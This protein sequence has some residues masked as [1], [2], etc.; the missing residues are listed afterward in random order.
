M[1]ADIK[2]YEIKISWSAED[3]CFFARVPAIEGCMSHGNTLEEAAG[4]IREAF[5]GIIEAMDAHGHEAPAPDMTRQRLGSVSRFLNLSALARES[6]LNKH[7]LRSKLRNG[8]RFTAAEAA[9][10]ERVLP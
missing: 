7:T 5:E 4:N 9:A 10:L 2:D 8:T 3:D 1:K 6:G